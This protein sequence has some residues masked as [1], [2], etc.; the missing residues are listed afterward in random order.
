MRTPA[1]VPNRWGLP[2][3]G[4]GV[5]LRTQHFRHITEKWPAMD[6]F[7]IV[8]ENFIDTEG[9]Q[10]RAGREYVAW[11][12]P[13]SYRAD[14]QRRS[15]GSRK[16]LN[17]KLADLVKKGIPGNDD[18]AVEKLFF[19]TG[20]LAAKRYNRCLEQDAYWQQQERTRAGAGLWHVMPGVPQ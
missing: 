16:R 1:P 5:G 3:L 10:G 11:H 8:S 2:D 18:R 17:R 19:Q 12:L 7:E 9:R 4:L 14:Y 13:N 6:W 15:H 20:A